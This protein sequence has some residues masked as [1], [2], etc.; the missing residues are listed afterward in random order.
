MVIVFGFLLA[1]LRPL[2]PLTLTF[3]LPSDWMVA[4]ADDDHGCD[5][6]VPSGPS[7]TN[8]LI[9]ELFSGVTL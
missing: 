9:V 2:K 8:E 6:V 7:M 4:A 3:P 5:S 1:D